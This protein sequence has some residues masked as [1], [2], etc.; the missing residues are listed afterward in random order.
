MALK[1]HSYFSREKDHNALFYSLSDPFNRTRDL[2]DISKWTLKRWI[3]EDSENIKFNDRRGRP[4][5]VD[6]FDKD[7]IGHA[8]VKMMGENKYVTLRTLRTFLKENH[9]LDLKRS[10]L[11][12]SVRSLGFS[13]K[14]TKSSKDVIC[15]SSTMISL[16]A[17]YLRKLKKLRSENYDILYLDESYINAHHTCPK[18]WQ[19][20]SIKREIPSGKGK[21]II[22]GHCG[23]YDKGLL[24]NSELIFESKCKDENG[25]FHKDMNYDEF[26]KWICHTVVPNLSKKNM[27]CNGQRIISQCN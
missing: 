26:N 27:S 16:R 14:K 12:R 21:R 10:T 2:L 13:F 19:S 9:N 18:E 3:N 6:S 17:R 22:I 8:V 24:R 5:K 4:T 1:L 20:E 11:W 15:E 25:D 7:L 23:S